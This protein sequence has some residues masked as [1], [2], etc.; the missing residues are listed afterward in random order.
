MFK[1][2]EIMDEV[3][4]LRVIAVAFLAGVP[5]AFFYIV[6]PARTVARRRIRWIAAGFL[7]MGTCYIG[8]GASWPGPN[9]VTL[10]M[11]GGGLLTFL[12]STVCLASS[13]FLSRKRGER[14]SRGIIYSVKTQFSTTSIHLT[15]NG[16]KRQ[17]GWTDVLNC[18]HECSGGST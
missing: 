4:I 15:R 11:M 5:V 14:G 13:L 8:W 9:S 16:S 3:A 18:A 1:V 7:G 17:T 10:C 2:E 6:R 12:V